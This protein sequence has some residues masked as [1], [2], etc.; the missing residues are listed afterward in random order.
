MVRMYI[1]DTGRESGCGGDQ[2]RLGIYPF[3]D[4]LGSSC[5]PHQRTGVTITVFGIVTT[6]FMLPWLV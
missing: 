2:E 1:F 5:Y 4:W 3:R 6:P